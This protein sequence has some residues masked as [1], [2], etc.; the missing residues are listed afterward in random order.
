MSR[1]GAGA[2]EGEPGRSNAELTSC[3]AGDPIPGFEGILVRCRKCMRV[4][5][6]RRERLP[7][8]HEQGKDAPGR[9]DSE[10]QRR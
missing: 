4:S 10:V 3:T 9:D 2:A 1:T 8:T 5:I 6:G 7:V